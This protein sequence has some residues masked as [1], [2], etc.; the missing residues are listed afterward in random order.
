MKYPKVGEKFYWK[1]KDGKIFEDICLKIEAEDIPTLETMFFIFLTENGGG[2][3]VSESNII[4][5]NSI[6]VINFK[7]EQLKKKL[8]EISDYIS[9]KEVYNILLDKLNKNG[10]EEVATS[11]LDI[12][13]DYE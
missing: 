10:F 12:L 4:D 3:F 6:E 9:Q 7:K 11:I 13:K 1:N 5:S 2:S 8:K